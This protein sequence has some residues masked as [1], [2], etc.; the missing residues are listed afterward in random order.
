M[1]R[2]IDSGVT[3]GNTN[4]AVGGAGQMSLAAVLQVRAVKQP[5]RPAFTFLS[6]DQSEAT[7]CYAELG[8]AARR[9]AARLAATCKAGDRVLLLLPPGLDYVAAMFGCFYAGCIA[10]P[11]YPP[12]RNS[13]LDRLESIVRDTDAAVAISTR[14]IISMND[15]LGKL[16][17]GRLAVVASEDLHAGDAGDF[18]PRCPVSDDIALLQYTSGSTDTPRGVMVSHGNLMHNSSFIYELYGHSP[19]SQGVIWL[20]PYHDMGL[21]GGILQPV[22]AGFPCTLMSPMTFLQRPI[23]WLQSI[24]RYGGTTSGGPNFAYDLCLK[25]VKPEQRETLDLSS[26]SV[27]FNGAEPISSESLD[28]FAD[29]FGE[30]G[31]RREAFLPCYGLAEA[32]LMV[33][34][35]DKEEDP[36]ARIVSSSALR[37]RHTIEEPTDEADRQEI[38]SCGRSYPDQDVFVVNLDDGTRCPDGHVGEIWVRGPSVAQ[39]VLATCRRHRVNICRKDCRMRSAAFGHR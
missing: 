26:W 9:I 24:G 3:A 37:D 18:V 36:P 38:V 19:D 13:T 28:R 35:V 12:R 15:D 27:A 31:F 6:D 39:G 16:G 5:S 14:S 21:I 11:A 8:E 29:Y 25:R 10:V 1:S 2:V 20:P 34:G 7:V 23:R 17:N 33:V 32:T 22:Y 30:C 4:V